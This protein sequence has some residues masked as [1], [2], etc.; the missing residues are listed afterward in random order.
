MPRKDDSYDMIA[1]S[2][3]GFRSKVIGFFVAVIVIGSF[4]VIFAYNKEKKATGAA[5]TSL[6]V[7][8]QS[9][10]NV[11]LNTA[12]DRVVEKPEKQDVQPQ[13]AK[14]PNLFKESVHFAFNNADVVASELSIIESF[15]NKIK[16]EKGV[17]VISGYTDSIGS[18]NY[19][20]TLSVKRATE[21]KAKLK[22]MGMSDE[23]NVKVRGLGASQPI[24][25]NETDDGRLKNRR[26]EITFE[27]K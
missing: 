1:S 23:Y 14:A 21:V 8:S 18:E 16:G 20:K 12:P 3:K 15:W 26:V 17:V 6:E 10:S 13:V 24:G 11:I 19:N 9:N 2:N 7:Q 4:I 25:D 27:R 5:K 22:N